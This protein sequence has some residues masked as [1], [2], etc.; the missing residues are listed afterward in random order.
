MSRASC[1]TARPPL[2]LTDSVTA[3]PTWNDSD[4]LSFKQH[5]SRRTRRQPTAMVYDL[6]GKNPCLKSVYALFMIPPAGVFCPAAWKLEVSDNKS[7]NG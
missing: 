6:G 7:Q 4:W 1:C 3:G 2:I 5:K